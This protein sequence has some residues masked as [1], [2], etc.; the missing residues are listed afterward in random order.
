MKKG[1]F[2]NNHLYVSD[3]ISTFRN[4]K[5]NIKKKPILER[6]MTA[7]YDFNRYREGAW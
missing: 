4:I 5:R 7:F 6:R 3:D 2:L 1:G